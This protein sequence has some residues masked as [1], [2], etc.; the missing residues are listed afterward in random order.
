[1]DEDRA[2]S[3]VAVVHAR[4][5]DRRAIENM[6]QLYVHDFTEL[7]AGTSRGELPD[8]GLFPLIPLDDYWQSKD[9][10]PLLIRVDGHLAGFALIDKNAHSGAALD[11]NMAEFF[12]ARKHRRGGVGRRAAHTIFQKRRGVWEA[13][14]ARRNVAALWFWRAAIA[15]LPGVRDMSEQDQNDERWNGAILRFRV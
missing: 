12:V 10:E 4:R 11:F 13:A 1:M 15:S 3:H 5:E 6:F 7:W 8:D 2:A 9:H 14:V